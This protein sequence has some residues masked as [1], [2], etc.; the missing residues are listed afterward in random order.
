M[1]TETTIKTQNNHKEKQN[2]HKE[3]QNDK[4]ETQEMQ[5]NYRDARQK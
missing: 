1:T 3:K 5:N 2:N 4:R